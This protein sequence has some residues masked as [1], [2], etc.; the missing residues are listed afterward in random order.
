MQLQGSS[1][2]KQ[3]SCPG[4]CTLASC[5]C[6][7][8]SPLTE[9][10]RPLPNSFLCRNFFT[11]IKA[12]ASSTEQRSSKLQCGHP[13]AQAEK[14]NGEILPAGNGDP[15]SARTSFQE[16]IWRQNLLVKALLT[17]P[18]VSQFIFFEAWKQIISHFFAGSCL[19]IALTALLPY[20]LCIQK[21]ML[22]S[23]DLLLFV[24][25]NLY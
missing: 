4:A 10:S 16:N 7:T 18:V 25:T 19:A 22:F 6:P 3:S 8:P 9:S 2:R 14:G 11:W 17:I 20:S 15:L 24:L 12:S 23:V 1:C 13:K 21:Q 5:G